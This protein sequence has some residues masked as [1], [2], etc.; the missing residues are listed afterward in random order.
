MLIE[1]S[2]GLL[3]DEIV[4]AM[5]NMAAVDFSS[6]YAQF[7]PQFLRSINIVNSQQSEQLLAVFHN[8]QA[9]VAL[10]CLAGNV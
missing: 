5:Y 9:S 8:E 6:F 4:T 10:W 1:R 2:H 3:H 7:L